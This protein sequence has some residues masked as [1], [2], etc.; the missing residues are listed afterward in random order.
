M[1]V[2]RPLLD[3]I[4]ADPENVPS[5]TGVALQVLRIVEDPAAT[6]AELE[7]TIA[8]DP[9]LTARVLK[10]VNSALFG[11][12]HHVSSHHPRGPRRPKNDRGGW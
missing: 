7:R 6:L 1:S 5:Q 9:A 12:R 4:V 2:A 8:A 10:T 3:E 11:V